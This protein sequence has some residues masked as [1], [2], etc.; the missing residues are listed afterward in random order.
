MSRSPSIDYAKL[1]RLTHVKCELRLLYLRIEREQPPHVEQRW[2]QTLSV[3]HRADEH[4]SKLIYE[5][6]GVG[7]DDDAPDSNGSGWIG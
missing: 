3:L 5:L 2:T 1:G 6:C 4:L 7:Q